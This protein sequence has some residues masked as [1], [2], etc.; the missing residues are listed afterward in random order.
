MLGISDSV[1]PGVSLFQAWSGSPSYPDTILAELLVAPED[2]KTALK[3][4]MYSLMTSTHQFIRQ[5]DGT[6]EIFNFLLDPE[7]QVNLADSAS[8]REMVKHFEATL[9]RQLAGSSH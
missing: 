2:V 9:N 5:S 1:L 4:P 6:T 3:P 7:D 8:S